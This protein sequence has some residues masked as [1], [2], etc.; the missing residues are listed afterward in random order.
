MEFGKV[1]AQ[2]VQDV[3]AKQNPSKQEE[4]LG[5]ELTMIGSGTGDITLG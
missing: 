1:E 2:A 5:L 3:I 4:L